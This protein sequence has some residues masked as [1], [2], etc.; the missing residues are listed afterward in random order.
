MMK[1]FL[2]I[3]ATAFTVLTAAAQQIVETHVTEVPIEANEQWWGMSADGR[4]WASCRAET[5]N[6]NTNML[7]SSAGRYLWSGGQP[8][9]IRRDG[10]KLVVENTGRE[11]EVQKGGKT[12]REAYLVCVHKNMPEDRK[13]P[14]EWLF[15]H[16]VYRPEVRA[17]RTWGQDEILDYARRIVA[18]GLP[19]GTLVI[20]W[21]WQS[22]NTQFAFSPE[23]FP[24]PAAM[25]DELHRMGFRAMLSVSSR[26]PALGR[27]Y[28]DAVA[29]G[30]AGPVENTPTGYQTAGFRL[31]DS[32]V[33]EMFKRSVAELGSAYDFDGFRLDYDQPAQHEY[34]DP[35][36]LA[37]TSLADGTDMCI[38]TGVYRRP[39]ASYVSEATTAPDGVSCPL[40]GNLVG[41]SL[42]GDPY[43][44]ADAR[45]L[46]A[47][48]DEQRFRY[49]IAAL[50]FPVASVD[51]VPW[52]IKERKLYDQFKKA[53]EFRVSIGDYVEN[54]AQE[55]ART[56]EPIVRN[57]EYQF[58]RNGFSDCDDQFMLGPK[59]LIAP[60][61]ADASNRMV[62][63]PK[64]RWT[65]KH[66]VKHR[67][68]VVL[69]VDCNDGLIYF[70]STK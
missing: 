3:A 30:L 51:F 6:F 45:G 9:S 4:S 5:G 17:D 39:F 24:D 33:A 13:V 66:G 2:T 16:P 63:L 37:W 60:C 54:L 38:M 57:M 8:M 34:N 46:D 67:G 61:T 56:G 65:D 27:V 7:L 10:E 28:T 49:M 29:D 26:V 36:M 21:Q 52:E 44:M 68:P 20:P 69:Q 48:D 23:L 11:I 1:R 19:V 59:Y 32:R 47:S 43:K 18:E 15:S 14:E 62:R 12:L 31:D 42:A 53:L 55:A 64:G 41:A 25:L 50:C 40:T 22:L 35:G 70:E 58:P